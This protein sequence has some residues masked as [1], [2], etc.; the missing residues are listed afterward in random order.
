M[1]RISYVFFKKIGTIL[2]L[3][4]DNKD[5]RG[6]LQSIDSTMKYPAKLGRALPGQFGPREK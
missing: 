6:G 5:K 4:F 2:V 1:I 3:E